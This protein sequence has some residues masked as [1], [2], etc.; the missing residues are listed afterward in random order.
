MS[1]SLDNIIQIASCFTHKDLESGV[2]ELI[3][4]L[5]DIAQKKFTTTWGRDKLLEDVYKEYHAY[6][7]YAHK[8]LVSDRVLPHQIHDKMPKLQDERKLSR[9]FLNDLFQQG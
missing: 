7:N 9:V 2:E 8:V 6:S 3:N 4:L 5:R 1:V